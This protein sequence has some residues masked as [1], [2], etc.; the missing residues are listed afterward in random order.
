MLRDDFHAGSDVDMLVEIDP[1]ARITYF[2][3]G[4][5]REELTDMLRREVELRTYRELS[6]YFRDRV[7]S[8]S[9]CIYVR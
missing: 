7:V 6:P 3:K 1:V 5:M 9:E 2:D 8:E 4:R